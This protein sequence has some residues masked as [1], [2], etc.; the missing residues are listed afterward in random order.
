MLIMRRKA[1]PVTPAPRFFGD[2][3]ANKIKNI[4]YSNDQ[5]MDKAYA[6]ILTYTKN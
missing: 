5:Q 2:W 6:R 1:K 3:M 4:H